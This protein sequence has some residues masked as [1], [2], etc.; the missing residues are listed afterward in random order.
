MKAKIVLPLKMLQMRTS[1][2]QKNLQKTPKK[3][4]I[5]SRRIKKGSR[6]KPKPDLIN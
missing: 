3:I 2:P 6:S 4:K 1:L 5:R